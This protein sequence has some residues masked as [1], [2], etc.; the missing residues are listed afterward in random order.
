MTRPGC[1]IPLADTPCFWEGCKSVAYQWPEGVSC[2]AH[3][4][5]LTQALDSKANQQASTFKKAPRQHPE[6]DFQKAII[7]AAHL[8]GYRVAHFRPAMNRRGQWM[9]A[10]AADG[11]GFPDLMMVRPA[12]TIGGSSWRL[13]FV[14]LKTAKGKVSEAQQAWLNDLNL[15]PAEVYVWRVGEISIEEIVEILR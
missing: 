9:T 1:E 7:D 8:L 4:E 10:V 2:Y 5:L 11:A 14:E 13:L 12:N 6:A 15:T 3:Y